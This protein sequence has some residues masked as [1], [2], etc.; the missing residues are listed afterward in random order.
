ANTGKTNIFQF[1]HLVLG[2]AAIFIHV[3]A[4]VISIDTVINYAGSMGISLI[5]AK[6]FPSYTLG[7][8]IVGYVLGISVIPRWISQKNMLRVLTIMGAVLSLLIV[9]VHGD[10]T[11][12][13]H[14][15]DVSIWFV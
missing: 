11:I 9:F 8:A 5:E 12:F 6:V 14:K 3:G 1:P 15:T 4:Q 13:G 7:M 2:A 10:V